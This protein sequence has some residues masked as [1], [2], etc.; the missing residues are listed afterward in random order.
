MGNNVAI[1][2]E[3]SSSASQ[4]GGGG[5]GGGGERASVVSDTEH[6]NQNNSADKQRLKKLGSV[7]EENGTLVLTDEDIRIVRSSWRELQSNDIRQY[8][9]N[10]M[11][12]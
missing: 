12:K 9:T 2:G 5:G 11:I 1:K 6:S 10:M 8:G 4:S 3:N 7:K